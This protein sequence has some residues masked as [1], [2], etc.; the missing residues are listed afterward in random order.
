MD[1]YVPEVTLPPSR[2]DFGT[3]LWLA[4]KQ[5][6]RIPKQKRAP[7]RQLVRGVAADLTQVEYERLAERIEEAHFIAAGLKKPSPPVTGDDSPE[8]NFTAAGSRPSKPGGES[9]LTK[10]FDSIGWGFNQIKSATDDLRKVRDRFQPLY[11]YYFPPSWITVLK[12]TFRLAPGPDFHRFRT[13][14]KLVRDEAWSLVDR[15]REGFESVGLSNAPLQTKQ[16]AELLYKQ[17]YLDANGIILFEAYIRA[18]DE[19]DS[20]APNYSSVMRDFFRDAAKNL[21]EL[22]KLGRDLRQLET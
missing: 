12:Q 3:A 8:A 17:V 5:S 22:E 18:L 13:E 10:G 15:A 6:L 16:W 4:F 19:R 7:V 9:P 2:S 20:E 14:V 11:H 1:N 21:K